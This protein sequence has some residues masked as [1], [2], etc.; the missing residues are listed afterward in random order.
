MRDLVTR[1]PLGLIWAGCCL[2]AT[3][4]VLVAGSSV[5]GPVFSFWR[6]WFGVAVFGVL[7]AVHVRTTG[8][9]PS[10]QAWAWAAASGVAF[11]VDQL[12]FMTAVKE[13]SVVDVLLVGT[14]GPLV[15]AV[16]A[17]PMFGERTG[18]AF[19]VWTVVAIAG[20]AVV[21]L[22]GSTGPE[23]RPL[24]MILA[25]LDVFAFTAFFML[26]KGGR[27]HADTVPFLFGVMCVAAVLVSGYVAATGGAV[28]AATGNDVLLTFATAVVPGTLGHFVMTWPLKWV[29]ANVPPVMRLSI[30]FLSGFMAWVFLGE[31]ITAAHVVGGLVTMAG[32]AGALLS[33]AGRRLMA[34]RPV[35]TVDVGAG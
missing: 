12:L 5:S 30:P 32:V 24:G 10:R 33:P 2:Y 28:G 34:Q 16:A 13:T 29:P 35:T 19:R 4:P 20:S 11:G 9:R 15:T 23:G 22:A 26:S 31:G 6:L 14:L 27:D 1:H 21:V 7:A 25:L 8:R 3:G 18:A 17:V